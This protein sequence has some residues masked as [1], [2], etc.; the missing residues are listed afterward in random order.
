MEWVQKW[1][2]GTPR[3]IQVLNWNAVAMWSWKAVVDNCA[4]CRNNVYDLCIECQ[5]NQE[6]ADRYDLKKMSIRGHP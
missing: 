1:W 4:I 6:T 2:Y 3:R 5:A